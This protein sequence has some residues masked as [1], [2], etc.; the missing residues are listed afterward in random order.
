MPA[1]AVRDDEQAELGRDQQTI[2]VVIPNAT[3]VAP[4]GPTHVNFGLLSHRRTTPIIESTSLVCHPTEGR[5]VYLPGR[6]ETTEV[7]ERRLWTLSFEIG[8]LCR[9]RVAATME[10]CPA[11]LRRK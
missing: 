3:A 10:P 2:L 1:H 4:T 7:V 11:P 9:F 5:R 8:W 6:Q